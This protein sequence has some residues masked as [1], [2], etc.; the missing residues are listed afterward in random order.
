MN[1]R[2]DRKILLAKNQI[3]LNIRD[4]KTKKLKKRY[5]LKRH[6]VNSAFFCFSMTVISFLF[7]LNPM[8]LYSFYQK[9]VVCLLDYMRDRKLLLCG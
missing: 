7:N 8:V 3:N 9:K 4:E 1:G 6:W 5:K 2:S